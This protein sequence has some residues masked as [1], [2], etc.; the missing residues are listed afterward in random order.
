MRR[1]PVVVAAGALL[2]GV[3]VVTLLVRHYRGPAR[4]AGKTAVVAA[5][6]PTAAGV[7]ASPIDLAEGRRTLQASI[8]ALKQQYDALEW[9]ATTPGEIGGLLEHV[10]GACLGFVRAALRYEPYTGVLRGGQGALSAG[11]GNSADLAVLLYEMLRPGMQPSRLR[12]AVADLTDAQ[13]AAL[14]DTAARTPPP[15]PVVAV[16]GS[17][18]P[19]TPTD[20]G[21]APAGTEPAVLRRAGTE[22]SDSIRHAEAHR[23]V[24]DPLLSAMPA[25]NDRG[26]AMA[27]ARQHVW[28]QVEEGGVWRDLDPVL[29]PAALQPAATH[30]ILPREWQHEI[31]IQVQ[32]E[33]TEGERLVRR[34]L[35]EQSW[36]SVSLGARGLQLVIS[37]DSVSSKALLKDASG[38]PLVERAVRW[39]SFRIALGAS[40][41]HPVTSASFDLSGATSAR[42]PDAMGLGSVNPF[43]RLSRPGVGA[44]PV[45]D[46]AASSSLTG[47]RLAITLRGPGL[48][49]ATI[50]RW[51]IDRIG[52]AARSASRAAIKPE[53]S[54]RG[55]VALSLVQHHAIIFP[56]GRVGMLQAARESLEIIA[57][58]GLLHQAIDL[59][60][61]TADPVSVAALTLPSMPVELTQISDTALSV[62]DARLAGVGR[63]YLARPNIYIRSESLRIV[64]GAVLAASGIDIAR[65][66]V[67]TLGAGPLAASARVAHGLLVSELE[68]AAIA[69][70]GEPART[71]WAANVLRAQPVGARFELV[72]SA[73]DLQRVASDAD[74]RAVMA[75]QIRSGYAVIAV[76]GGA[77][78]VWWRAGEG[79]VL[80]M[81]ADGRGQAG[82]EGLVVLEGISIPSVERTMKFVGCFNEAIGGGGAMR[83]SAA[84][85]LSQA[86]Y[87]TVKASLDR[88]IDAYVMDPVRE[89]MDAGRAAALGEEYEALYQK[90]QT[91]WDAY[92]AAQAVLDDP[93]GQTID[94]IPGVQQGRDVANAGR[95]IGGAFGFR[96]YLML[97]MGRDIAEYGSK[98]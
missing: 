95:R 49:D 76:A 75:E 58:S 60:Q 30:A 59:K 36:P 34:D 22:L 40:G 35:L 63:A 5:A 56:V 47:V 1:M 16:R 98:L 66:D 39:K 55:V 48:P 62:T 68:G 97:T 65:N 37:P 44:P 23:A 26:A 11:A 18:L 46:P 93:I 80:A 81:G 4:A 17:Q 94:Q 8:E 69:R 21:S 32:L 15:Q 84:E 45:A 29:G 53:W 38:R 50:E 10:P 7:A 92:Q 96:L 87:D 70:P 43:G 72:R 71:T 91:A 3:A 27:A 42:P 61:G 64:D 85:C 89:G 28:L 14:V 77:G 78:L 90:A 67:M 73:S 12:F 86:I 19:T 88:A 20:A 9:P 74:A 41:G 33:S 24:L 51:L 57:T 2:I 6:P 79:T 13:A 54:H 52:P 82:S 31:R 25:R 83:A